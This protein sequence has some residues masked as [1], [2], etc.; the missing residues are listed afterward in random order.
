MFA[1]TGGGRKNPVVTP[2]ASASVVA[3]DTRWP[4]KRVI[5]VM[6]ENRSFD[7]VYGKFPGANGTTV[8]VKYGEEVPLGNC[9]AW[10]PGD[11]PHDRAAH[12]NDVNGGTY[13]GV[14]IV[15]DSAVRLFTARAAG[16]RALG[17]EVA[18][19]GA[20]AAAACCGSTRCCAT[21]SS[22]RGPPG[23]APCCR[24]S[25]CS[26]RCIISRAWSIWPKP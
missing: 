20:A 25:T 13:D 24:T 7:N 2:S 9:P 19:G 1:C 3:A 12:L 23:C 5:Y 14:R 4:I 10:L 15:S 26:C 17:W 8:G 6:L 11:I 16:T 22:R 18:L 21:R